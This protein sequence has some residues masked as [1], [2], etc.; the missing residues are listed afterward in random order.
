MAY[1]FDVSV[2]IPFGDDEDVIG[3]A[4]RRVAAHLREYGAT[5][6]IVAVDENS[7]DNSHAVLALLRPNLPELC[8]VSALGRGRGYYAGAQRARGRVLWLIGPS[9]AMT[10]LAPF[11]RAYRRVERGELDMV[12][13]DHRFV[14]FRRTNLLPVIEGLRGSGHAYRRRL[15]KRAE[16]RGL[17]TETLVIG[18]ASRASRGLGHAAVSWLFEA[19]SPVRLGWNPRA[20]RPRWY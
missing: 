17:A 11:G 8:I 3:A 4:V 13:V 15:V 12:A 9:F 14:V 5:F 20:E 19:I 6:E 7:G 2:V 10:P 18:G 1:T 16:A